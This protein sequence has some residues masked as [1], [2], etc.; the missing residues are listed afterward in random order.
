M[1]TTLERVNTLIAR[2]LERAKKAIAQRSLKGE[3]AERVRVKE[4]LAGL[5][6][7]VKEL[8]KVVDRL[9]AR[10]KKRSG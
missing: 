1:A 3:A 7:S 9:Q 10:D 5:E 6:A 4:R 8:A 2:P